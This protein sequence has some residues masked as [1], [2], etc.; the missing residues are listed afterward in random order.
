MYIIV[1][2][3]ELKVIGWNDFVRVE[4]LHNFLGI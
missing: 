2:M 1:L 4:V 3:I